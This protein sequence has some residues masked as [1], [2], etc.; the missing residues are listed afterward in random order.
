MEATLSVCIYFLLCFFLLNKLKRECQRV[1]IYMLLLYSK[2]LIF[3]YIYIYFFYFFF[4]IVT[5]NT[6][7]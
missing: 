7:I 3:I 2:T 6:F 4:I 5:Q 1:S